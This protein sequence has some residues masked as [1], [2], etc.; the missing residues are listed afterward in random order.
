MWLRSF[1]FWF[2]FLFV[3]EWVDVCIYDIFQNYNFQINLFALLVFWSLFAWVHWRFLSVCRL[4]SNVSGLTNYW[5]KRT[6]ILVLCFGSFNTTLIEGS[7]VGVIVSPSMHGE[8]V[9]SQYE[10]FT[11]GSS[12]DESTWELAVTRSCFSCSE[13]FLNN[14]MY[15]I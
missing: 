15:S 6:T 12:E 2:R 11:P 7:Q 8:S 5:W 10:C 1:I 13:C 4:F 14:V 3:C 9:E